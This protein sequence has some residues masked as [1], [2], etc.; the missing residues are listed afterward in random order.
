M[1]HHNHSNCQEIL[2]RLN[3]F[4]DGELDPEMCARLESHMESCTNCQIVYNTLKK[5]I[6]LCQKD[7]KR[8]T[9][10]PDIRF[11]LLNS[12]GLEDDA[13]QD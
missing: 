3:D 6:E 2:G 8:T 5:T 13:R 4:I 11:R 10:P 7:G 9:L 1:M 12:L